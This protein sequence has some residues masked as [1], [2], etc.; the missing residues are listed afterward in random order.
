MLRMVADFLYLL[1]PPPNSFF[2]LSNQLSKKCDSVRGGNAELQE[3]PS[4][5]HTTHML[6]CAESI[7]PC[8][9]SAIVPDIGDN[10]PML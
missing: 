7:C 9:D 2:Q 10:T 5:G 3:M 8:S 6:Q 1:I 4:K